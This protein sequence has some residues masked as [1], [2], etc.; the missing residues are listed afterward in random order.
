MKY[1]VRR[2]YHANQWVPDLHEVDRFF[3]QVFGRKSSTLVEF[4]D[5]DESSLDPSY[6]VDYARF[7]PIAEVLFES[8][9]PVRHIVNGL[10]PHPAVAA[11]CLGSV[12]WFV[13]GIEDLWRAFQARGMKGLDLARQEPEGDGPPRDVSNNPII[14][15]IPSDTG[16]EYQFSPWVERRDPRGATPAS[17]VSSDDPLGIRRCSHHTVLTGDPDR[18]RRMYRDLLGGRIIHEGRNEVLATQSTY[19]ALGDG[20][21]EVGQPLEEGSHAMS[22]WRRSAPDDTYYQMTYQVRDTDQV[23]DHVKSCGVGLLH[24]DAVIITDPADTLGVPWGFTTELSP[25]DS[26]AEHER[27]AST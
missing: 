26:R 18:A 5:L 21:F 11:P 23:V 25:G 7:T 8:L 19:Y 16:L 27:A 17:A 1:H 14:F 3:A 22:T 2:L 24:D 6:P 13:D 9:D 15:S 4:M 12:A 10:Q 20:V